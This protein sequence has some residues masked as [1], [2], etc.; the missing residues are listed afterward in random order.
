[1]TAHGDFVD[2]LLALFGSGTTNPA[3]GAE[4][5]AVHPSSDRCPMNDPAISS[6]VET[7]QVRAKE[8]RA[9][10]KRLRSA[11]ARRRMLTAA[12]DFE[13]LA[14]SGSSATKREEESSRSAR[15]T[16]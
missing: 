13:R 16:L 7:W 9:A 12:E 6:L 2:K 14:I 10:A 3:I 11:D 4:I 1:M 15:M 8:C 5:F